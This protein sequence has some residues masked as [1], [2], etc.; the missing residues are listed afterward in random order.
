MA[1]KKQGWK[2]KARK[3]KK[4]KKLSIQLRRKQEILHKMKSYVD[5][6]LDNYD[7]PETL[8]WL[9]EA[10]ILDDFLYGIGIA[11]NEDEYRSA[12]GYDA[13]K[14]MLSQKIMMEMLNGRLK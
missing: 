10:S 11:I 5:Q 7:K 4:P 1:R 2:P 8:E 6:Y 12:D 3:A 9:A 13:F 14:K